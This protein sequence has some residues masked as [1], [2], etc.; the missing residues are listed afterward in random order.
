MCNI[1]FS[2]SVKDNSQFDESESV[3]IGICVNWMGMRVIIY[4]IAC[5]L[6]V[7]ALHCILSKVSINSLVCIFYFFLYIFQ[8]LLVLLE[9]SGSHDI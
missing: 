8:F 4:I 9:Q 3:S 5:K 6:H 7:D 2:V 1:E